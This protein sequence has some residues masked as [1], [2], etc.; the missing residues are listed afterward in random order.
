MV[1]V[2]TYVGLIQDK[3]GRD[4]QVPWNEAIWLEPLSTLDLVGTSVETFGLEPLN[5]PVFKNVP[6]FNP[7]DWKCN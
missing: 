4:I 1:N 5:I 3:N 2:E 6:V 7:G